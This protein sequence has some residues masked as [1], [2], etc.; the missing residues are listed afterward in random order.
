MIQISRVYWLGP[1]YFIGLCIWIC[2]FNY[3][4]LD[5]TKHKIKILSSTYIKLYTSTTSYKRVKILKLNYIYLL[6]L[7]REWN[8]RKMLMIMYKEICK[9]LTLYT[10]Y[11]YL[12]I[13]WLSNLWD[14]TSNLNVD[15]KSECDM[16]SKCFSHVCSLLKIFL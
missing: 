3:N 11:I 10:H 9:S 6:R 2:R 1:N 14:S 12:Y 7:I 5:F 13:S 8:K 15:Y 16:I 4:N